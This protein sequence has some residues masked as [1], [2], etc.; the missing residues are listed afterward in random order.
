MRPDCECLHTHMSTEHLP[1]ARPLE[2]DLSHCRDRLADCQDYP[3]QRKH[4]SPHVLREQAHL[5]FRTTLTAATMRLRDASMRDWHDWFEVRRSER[6]LRQ[7]RCTNMQDNEFV[8]IHTP[9]LTSSDCEGAGGVFKLQN[10]GQ[11]ESKSEPG[12]SSLSDSPPSGVAD[13]QSTSAS[14]AH[15]PPSPATFFPCPVNLTVSSQL[16]LEAPTHALSRTYTLSPSF[17]SERSMT[18]RHLAEFYMLEGELVVETLDGLLDV[19]EDGIRS[20]L[21]R[22]VASNRG[23]NQRM[24]KDFEAIA[25]AST[26]EGQAVVPDPSLTTIRPDLVHASQNPFTRIT[27]TQAVELLNAHPAAPGSGVQWGNGLGTEQEKWLASHFNGPVFVTHY[28]ASLKP[29]YMLPSNASENSHTETQPTVA[30][31]DLLVP[32]MG[33]LIGGSLREHRFDHLVEAVRRAGLDQEDYAWY[34]DLRRYGSIPHGGWGMGWERWLSWITGVSN[35]RDV[36]AFPRW[37]GH[38]KY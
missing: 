28:P 12:S 7:K 25:V 36:V 6:R 17:R 8:H 38:C 3:V 1:R 22:L 31:F 11:G 24:R 13:T 18:S 19:V 14:D 15:S 32:G 27:Y 35:V 21:R 2:N 23:R 4:L 34:L 30:C 20:S 10:C 26:P 33:E 9:L 5:R 37:M 29:F 16:H